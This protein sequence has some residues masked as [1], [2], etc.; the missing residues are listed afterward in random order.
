MGLR[1]K[2]DPS[3]SIIYEQRKE[4]QEKFLK[5]YSKDDVTLK[6]SLGR[7]LMLIIFALTFVVMIWG[8]A[9]KKWWFTEMTALFLVVGII[10]GVISRMGEKNFV[11]KFVAGSA[12]LVGV[13]LVIGVARS[14]NLVMENGMISDTILY[15]SSNM[16]A[17]MNSSVFIIFMLIV[18]IG[19]GFFIP[20]SSGLAVLSMPIMAPLADSVGLPREAIVNAYM[21]GQGLIS[22]ITPTGLILATLAMVDVTYDKWIKFI[23]PLMGYIAALSAIMLLIQS[24]VA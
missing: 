17:G 16:I 5:D 20:S 10:L 24:F 9:Y 12:D 23:M 21:F 11:D 14:I 18:F 19:L 8:V 1:L 13:A 22:F 2:K 6:F 15:H 3:K 7:K 4:I